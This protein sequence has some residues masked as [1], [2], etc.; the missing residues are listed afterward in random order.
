MQPGRVPVRV[1]KDQPAGPNQVQ[2]APTRL[3]AQQERKLQRATTGAL[4]ETEEIQMH[5]C[6]YGQQTLRTRVRALSH[7][8]ARQL[9]CHL[10]GG[11]VIKEVD[12]LLPL[13]NAGASV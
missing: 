4:Y 7:V 2:P 6:N 9:R 13:V 10:A 3:G 1:K 11:R 8:H 5:A 12:E